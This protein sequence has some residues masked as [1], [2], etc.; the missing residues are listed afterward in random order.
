MIHALGSERMILRPGRASACDN[1]PGPMS[2]WSPEPPSALCLLLGKCRRS[3][4]LS[5]QMDK[6]PHM[7]SRDRGGLEHF[8]L[9][10]T[11]V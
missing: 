6:K 5:P 10:N 11:R 4:N 1:G 3:H 2:Q 8:I 7:P 9:S